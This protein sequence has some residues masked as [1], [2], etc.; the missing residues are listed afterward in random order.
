MICTLRRRPVLLETSLLRFSTV[1][2]RRPY[3]QVHLSVLNLFVLGS[4]IVLSFQCVAALLNPINHKREATK[5]G[6]ISYTVGMFSCVTIVI[7]TGQNITSLSFIDN[8]G[9]PGIEGVFPPGPLGYQLMI[10]S[11]APRIAPNLTTLLSYWLADG[12]L[13][14]RLFDPA[15]NHPGVERRLL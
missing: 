7:A 2:P 14:S 5:W 9:F 12:L 13:V 8:R 6:L 15:S 1:R 4:L 3:L 11:K 10:C